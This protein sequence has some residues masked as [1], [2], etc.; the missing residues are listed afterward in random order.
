MKYALRDILL[1]VLF[2][3]LAAV[4]TYGQDDYAA[5]LVYE[6]ADA[7]LA[8][9]EAKLL[10]Y[11]GD[12][13]NLPEARLARLDAIANYLLEGPAATVPDDLKV[14][15]N[16]GSLVELMSLAGIGQSKGEKII[17]SREGNGPFTDWRDVMT[18]GVGIGPETYK[19]LMAEGRAY[20]E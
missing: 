10:L 20:I 19:D 5:P 14:N 12:I 11:A 3:S 2:L 16:T 18:R 1:V 6:V 4:A 9:I 8:Q 15:L 13:E 17:A 7:E